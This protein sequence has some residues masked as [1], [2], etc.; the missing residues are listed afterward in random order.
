[1]HISMCCAIQHTTCPHGA[2]LLPLNMAEGFSKRKTLH[3]LWS[4]QQIVFF[5]CTR[6]L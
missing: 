6:Y 5:F 4:V 1:M 3:L 2:P